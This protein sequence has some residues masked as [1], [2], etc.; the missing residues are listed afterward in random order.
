MCNKT[1]DVDFSARARLPDSIIREAKNSSKGSC[2]GGISVILSGRRFGL[3]V[4][5]G[6]GSG[7]VDGSGVGS[8]EPNVLKRDSMTSPLLPADA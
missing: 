7:G 5:L 8:E 4:G 3:G 2:A 1:S 6:V